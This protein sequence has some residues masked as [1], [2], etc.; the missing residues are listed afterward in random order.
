MKTQYLC[1][2]QLSLLGEYHNPMRH[3]LLV[4]IARLLS[5]FTSAGKLDALIQIS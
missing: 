4:P 3:G 1:V 5:N 2:K